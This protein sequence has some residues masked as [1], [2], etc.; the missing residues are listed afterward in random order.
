MRLE[1]LGPLPSETWDALIGGEH[2]PFGMGD[3][4]TE[5]RRKEHFTVLY[6]A[7]R[8]IAATGLL[9]VDQEVG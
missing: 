3:D 9:V 7:D 4:P 8:P 2:D 5:W 6:D 1:H